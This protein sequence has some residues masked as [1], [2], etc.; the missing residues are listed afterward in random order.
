MPD[1]F[2]DHTQGTCCE[3]APE[4][5]DVPAYLRHLIG[6]HSDTHGDEIATIKADLLGQIRG[7]WQRVFKGNLEVIF[8]CQNTEKRTLL[9]Q[10]LALSDIFPLVFGL[11]PHDGNPD[12]FRVVIEV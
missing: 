1:D 8:V 6:S 2:V 4:R 11:A 5:G 3:Y 12:R 7:E 9:A 10:T